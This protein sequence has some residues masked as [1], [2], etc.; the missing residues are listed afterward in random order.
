MLAFLLLSSAAG[1]ADSWKRLFPNYPTHGFNDIFAEASNNVFS[2]G[3]HGLI[4]HFDGSSWSEMETPVAVDLNGI[5]GRA[6]NDIF[7]VGD[8]GTIIRYN[9]TTWIKMS[10]PT[11][12]H[13]FSIWGFDGS[14]NAVYAGGRNGEIL[15]YSG[16]RWSAMETP[17]RDGIWDYTTIY[18]IWGDAPSNLYAVG[19]IEGNKNEDV[20]LRYSGGTS[21]VKDETF[22][23]STPLDPTSVFGFTGHDVYISGG[24]GV[25]RLIN[26]TWSSGSW[27]KILTDGFQSIWGDSHD[28]IW[29]VGNANITH[30]NGNT[31]TV[32]AT[33]E[34]AYGTQIWGSNDQDVFAVT[35]TKGQIFH[36]QGE[37]WSSLTAVPDVPVNSVSGTTVNSLFAVGDDG[38]ILFYNG[39]HWTPMES[40]TNNRLNSVCGGENA[41]FAVGDYGT[42]LFYDGAKW[43]TVNS[44]KPLQHLYDAWCH[45]GSAA[46]VVGTNGTILNCSSGG[47]SAEAP[48]VTTA[49]L[50]AVHHSD[51]MGPYAG[52]AGGVML[53]KSSNTWTQITSLPAGDVRDIWGDALTNLIVT[54]GDEYIH[55]YDTTSGDS[56]SWTEIFQG[57]STLNLEAAVGTI[58]SDLYVVGY[59]GSYPYDGVVLHMENGSMMPIQ[60]FPEQHLRSA[61]LLSDT[62]FVGSELPTSNSPWSGTAFRY[63]GTTWYG[64]MENRALQDIW[65]T[66]S[67]N[68]FVAGSDGAVMHYDGIL[69]SV[70]NSGTSTDLNAVYTAA[71]GSWALAGG[72]YPGEIIR[73][74]GSS[75]S[76]VTLPSG[77]GFSD[78]WGSGST[79]YTVGHDSILSSF[80]Y[81]MTWSADSTPAEAGYLQAIW[82]A[83]INGPFFAVGFDATILTSQGD[84]SWSK[85]NNN[86]TSG[87]R[88]WDIWGSSAND[89]YAVGDTEFFLG[90][91]ESQILHFDGTS[92]STSSLSYNVLPAQYLNAV[93]G[94]SASDVFAFGSQSFRNDKC[95]SDWEQ[96]NVPGIPS[97]SAVWGKQ[98]P[99]GVYTIYAIADTGQA[100]YQYTTTADRKCPSRWSL[101]LP[102]ILSGR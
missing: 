94:R 23:G 91:N 53:H 36:Y 81:G 83:G 4:Y 72:G 74:D 33:S 62:L 80:N 41:A 59:G 82:G 28:S 14:T 73:Y 101:Y 24:D 18:G 85:M 32:L 5:W 45:S 97:F 30:Y 64:M 25:Y 102:A 12:V 50:Y 95:S 68:L 46:F 15:M 76:A 70:M 51:I 52:G 39:Q 47:C 13:L 26:G 55:S 90:S 27:K 69:W 21:W 9:G 92:W 87:L 58:F 10:S 60:N 67:G 17:L 3:N 56:G 88:L 78:F 35:G 22:S 42:V 31:S 6:S 79:V 20:F 54:V 75:W 61:V 2:V 37:A 84:G 43:S 71:D 86:G 57:S 34:V 48:G 66:D 8:D 49:S 38:S 19:Q 100:V 77:E 98:G 96:M 63:D 16:G 40:P 44:G 99:G 93:W 29:F 65:G 89:V 7:A 11:S 1:A